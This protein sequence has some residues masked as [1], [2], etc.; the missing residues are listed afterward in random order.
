MR[1][2]LLDQGRDSVSMGLDSYWRT[3]TISEAIYFAPGSDLPVV[4]PHR[5]LPRIADTRDGRMLS[6]NGNWLVRCPEA[7]LSGV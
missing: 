6:K 3:R 7:H 1:R 5:R 4:L 2:G